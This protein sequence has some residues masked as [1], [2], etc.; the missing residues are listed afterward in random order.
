M[1]DPFRSVATIYLTPFARALM[2][3][4]NSERA[5]TR[6]SWSVLWI[7]TSEVGQFGTQCLQGRDQDARRVLGD[8]RERVGALVLLGAPCRC[9]AGRE[10]TSRPRR[11]P[12]QR[13]P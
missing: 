11:A 10:P 13:L 9:G 7:A 6:S 4:A 2:A 5:H 1:R 12:R 3:A 8:E